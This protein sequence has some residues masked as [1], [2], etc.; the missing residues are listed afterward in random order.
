MLKYSE[1]NLRLSYFVHYKFH[2]GVARRREVITQIS[3]RLR[4]CDI[5]IQ[6]E[7]K[8]LSLDWVR[9]FPQCLRDSSL[10]P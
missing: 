7:W 3:E 5:K 6:Q 1:R 8:G 10:V 4:T 9:C 2:M